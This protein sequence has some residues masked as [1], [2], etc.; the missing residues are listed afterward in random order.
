MF[1]AT[2][3]KGRDFST[4]YNRRYGTSVE[5]QNKSL[6]T[7]LQLNLNETLILCHEIFQ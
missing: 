7:H 3:V 6:Y 4:F 1:G 2:F 5:L